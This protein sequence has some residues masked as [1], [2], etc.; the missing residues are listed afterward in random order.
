MILFAF[1]DEHNIPFIGQIKAVNFFE[2]KITFARFII[3]LWNIFR[4]HEI[5]STVIILSQIF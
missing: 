3:C 5:S 4:K 2:F 1:I